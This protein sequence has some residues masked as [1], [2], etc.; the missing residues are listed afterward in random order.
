MH[1]RELDGFQG[2]PTTHDAKHFNGLKQWF[3]KGKSSPSLAKGKI[4]PKANGQRVGGLLFE[5]HPKVVV[6]FQEDPFQSWCSPEE[7]EE[8]GDQPPPPN[9]A[10]GLSDPYE[11]KLQLPSFAAWTIR[12]VY[13]FFQL[14]VSLRMASGS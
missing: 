1:M 10:R 7:L 14:D 12:L 4:F 3:Q 9:T 6:P 13:L 5:A 11:Q 8:M 2:A